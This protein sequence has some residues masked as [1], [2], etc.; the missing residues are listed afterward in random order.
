MLE[1]N[2]QYCGN[3]FDLI[4]EIDDE[5]IDL[6][7]CD[8]PYGVTN[9]DWDKIPSIQEYN[10]NLLKLFSRVLK[11]GGSLYLFGKDNCIDFIDYR[12]YLQLNRK[13]IW[14]QPSRLAQGRVNYT[15]NYDLIAYFSK[16]KAK[17]FNLD[18]IRVPQMVELTQRLRCENVPSVKNGPYAKTKFNELGKNP[19]DVWG[20]IKQLTYHSKELVSREL[21]NTIQK[22]LKLIE[23]L[24]LASSNENDVILDPFSGV[25]TTMKVCKE[26]KR[27]FICCE[28]NQHY[29]DL[30]NNRLNEQKS[31]KE[32]LS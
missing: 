26:N 13:I 27:N 3:T 21:L 2:K 32:E 19:G 6:I 14:Y 23:R 15:N 16:G 25:G 17:T 18:A 20:D 5:S 28:M 31:D 4:N 9:N 11:P 22:P 7:V 24:V 29:I 30:A 12:K 10:L 1:L 8:G